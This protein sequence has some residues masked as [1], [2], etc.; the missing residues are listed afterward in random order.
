[1]MI[2]V[3]RTGLLADQYCCSQGFLCRFEWEHQAALPSE[4]SVSS[5]SG[6]VGEQAAAHLMEEVPVVLCSQTLEESLVRRGKAVICLV[7][8]GPLRSI[9]EDRL[10]VDLVGMYERE[11]TR[12][13]PPTLGSV[14]ILRIYNNA[15]Q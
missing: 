5:S 14:C 13:S 9:E 4:G 10:I 8:T 12:V 7:T 2:S 3:I 11:L 1:M 6:P 15:N